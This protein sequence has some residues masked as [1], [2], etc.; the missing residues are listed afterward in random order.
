M[1]RKRYSEQNML[2]LLKGI[3]VHL[4]CEVRFISLC[5]TVGIYAKVSVNW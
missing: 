5:R 1:A 3:G 4:T 2:R